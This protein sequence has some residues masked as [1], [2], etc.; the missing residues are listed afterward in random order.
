MMIL[1][2]SHTLLSEPH[3]QAREAVMAHPAG[4]GGVSV[5]KMKKMNL[6]LMNVISPGLV[7][8]KSVQAR[9]KLQS[10]EIS[11]L[12]TNFYAQRMFKTKSRNRTISCFLRT[13]SN[14]TVQK[15]YPAHPKKMRNLAIPMTDLNQKKI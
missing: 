1:G 15:R 5:T 7:Q 11:L 9:P 2:L 10:T 6:N 14:E 3:L 4:V 12:V 13:I 8:T